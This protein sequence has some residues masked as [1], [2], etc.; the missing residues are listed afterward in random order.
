MCL[1][2]KIVNQEIPA[3]I[4]YQ[5]EKVLCFLDIAPDSAGHVLVIPKQHCTNI[6]DCNFDVSFEVLKKISNLL[7]EKLKCD[8]I[9]MVV[10][11]NKAAGQVVFHMHVHLIP[12]YDVELYDKMDFEKIISLLEA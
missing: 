5:D 8:G 9:K 7:V 4:I 10:N 3:N 11:N 2:C 12:A 1:F 6:L